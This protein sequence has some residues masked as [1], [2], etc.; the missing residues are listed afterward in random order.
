MRLSGKQRFALV[1][2]MMPKEKRSRLFIVDDH[3]LMRMGIAALINQ[4]SDLAVCGEAGDAVQALKLISEIHPDLAIVD[5]S[6]KDASG[7]EL[8][9]QIKAR[10][11]R[12]A[13]LVVS[14][15]DEFLYAERAFRA[16]AMG[17]VMKQETPER[18]LEAIRR[19]LRGSVYMSDGLNEKMVYQLV[20]G[21][22][23]LSPSPME[24]LSD[25]EMEV[26][27]LIGRGFKICQISQVM[28]VSVKT[29]ETY[30]NR[31]KEKLNIK[32]S[33]ELLQYAIQWLQ[34]KSA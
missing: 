6:L 8:I 4:E 27:H 2:A 31:I 9:K 12:I 20:T 11:D 23:G 10:N 30:R 26:F 5:L 14:M 21:H 29:V 34:N 7:I 24:Q 32:Q 22:S 17:Y 15:Y 18:L 19:V 16:G 3:P 1:E 28:N 25:R 13:I 33:N